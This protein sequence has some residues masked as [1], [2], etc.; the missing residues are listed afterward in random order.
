MASTTTTLILAF[1]MPLIGFSQE[2]N[3]TNAKNR[4]SQNKAKTAQSN[5]LKTHETSIIIELENSN[6][7]SNTITVH[8]YNYL[9]KDNTAIQIVDSQ[10]I[11]SQ[12]V[13]TNDII[14]LFLKVEG[15]TRCTFDQATQT[16]T[17][18][19]EPLTDLSNIVNSINKK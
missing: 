5:Q 6:A 18:L 11:E 1:A 16:F 8:T 4:L 7:V 9:E 2:T 12:S 19:S 13:E 15:V 10:P 17:I 3:T 14:E